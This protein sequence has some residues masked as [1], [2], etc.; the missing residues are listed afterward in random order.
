M[1]DNK[2]YSLDELV[3]HEYDYIFCGAGASSS[4]LLL[5][6]HKNGLLLEKK[7]L[8]IEPNTKT[9]NDKT[10]C[11]WSEENEEI[12]VDLGEIISHKWDEVSLIHNQVQSLAPYQ[13]NHISSIDLYNKIQSLCLQ[14]NWFTFKAFVEEIKADEEGP[15][16]IVNGYKIRSRYVFDSR[17]PEYTSN[18]ELA[19]H[20]Y[21]S[22]VGWMIETEKDISDPNAFRFMDFEI[23]QE[24]FTQFVYVLPFSKNRALVEVTR[25][26]AQVIEKEKCEAILHAYIVHN[27]GTY[28]I[29]DKEFGCI[30][31][32][33]VSI[34][35]NPIPG[36]IS[37][38]A[39]SYQI[40]PS[41][42]YAFKNMY[43]H[44]NQIVEMIKNN[45]LLQGT[46]ELNSEGR[47]G[48]FALYD[49]L[50][51]DILKNKPT[52][53]KH[54]FMS[55]L[56]RVEMP[57]VLRFLD[58]KTNI[59]DDISIFRNL[60]WGIFLSTFFKRFVH[61]TSFRP[62]ILVLIAS[63]L[64]ILGVFSSYQHS[65][66]YGLVIIGL[67]TVGIPHGALDHLID[68]NTSHVFTRVSLLFVIKYLFLAMCMLGLWYVESHLA[69]LFF[70]VYSAWHFGQA[71]GKRWG[72]S[73]WLS[74][75]W[76]AFLLLFIL[77]THRNETNQI[78]SFLSRF[79]IQWDFSNLLLLPWLV[80][81][82]MKKNVSFFLTVVV[83]LLSSHLPL[84]IA[85]GLYFIGQHS[86][87][88]WI[89]IKKHLQLSHTKMWRYAL[90]FHIAA[91]VLLLSF[92]FLF[93]T[94]HFFEENKLWALFF[95][96]ISSISFP[97][98]VVMHRLYVSK[99]E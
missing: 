70:I 48:R 24:G 87:S 40:K 68:L 29:Q 38:G 52:E 11:F 74:F 89:D 61:T 60:P 14:A 2:T 42:G 33:N 44:A 55:L 79:S 54:I 82:V 34:R 57:K 66:G 26:G 21:Q 7:V 93:P 12:T 39:R 73:A 47:R 43:C 25:F 72:F 88:G 13:Y 36:V 78:L 32:S 71:D 77:G 81:A 94:F 37:I 91:W 62:T 15:F 50:L 99:N 69:L 17:P 4:L 65:V 46:K 64:F 3:I 19:V 8:I 41:S 28:T 20:I 59:R 22:F 45:N 84:F 75:F 83:L 76:G 63:L 80:Y 67:L 95:V 56:R 9:I 49:N 35:T 97:H 86:V 90:P 23:E 27:M 98:V 85:F 53:G 92:V 1:P 16:V 6:L 18:H 51:L 58:E 10:F 96:F 30:P 31:M 5:Q